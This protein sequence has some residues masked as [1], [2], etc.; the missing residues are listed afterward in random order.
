MK[1]SFNIN[2]RTNWG[3]SVYITGDIPELGNGNE[4]N[5]LQLSLDG[6]DKW[7]TTIEVEDAT[8]DFKYSY[9]IKH[10]NGYTRKEWGAGHNFRRGKSA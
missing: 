6:S 4:L 3:E 2:Y 9:I 10:E 8:P 5:A 7:H 1:I